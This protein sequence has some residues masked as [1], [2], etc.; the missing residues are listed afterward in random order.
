[1][2][3][4]KLFVPHKSQPTNVWVSFCLVAE[5]TFFRLR[6]GTFWVVGPPNMTGFGC[7]C[8]AIDCTGCSL[9]APVG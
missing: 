7:L 8:A 1:M 3:H 2:K 6:D 9:A 4:E 5:S